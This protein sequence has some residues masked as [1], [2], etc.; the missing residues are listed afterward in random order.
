[1]GRKKQATEEEKK[2]VTKPSALKEF[3]ATHAGDLTALPRFQQLLAN[4]SI[5][6]RLLN[7]LIGTVFE[8]VEATP[9]IEWGKSAVKAILKFFEPK[10]MTRDAFFFPSVDSERKLI[11][12]LRK[13]TSSMVICVFTITNNDLAN[14]IRDARR[15]GVTV[16][17]I[18][19]D[20]CMKMSGSDIQALYDEGF[21]VRTD[22]NRYAHMHNKFVVIDEY[23][24][25]TGSFNWTKQAVKKNQENL[26]VL[27]DPAL[28]KIYIEEF[29]RLWEAFADSERRNLQ[30]VKKEDEQGTTGAVEEK[31]ESKGNT[32]AV[33]EEKEL[34]ID[35]ET[36]EEEK[37]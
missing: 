29:N 20:E 6:K 22:L 12:Y 11:S 31:K 27:D 13:A 24:L 1:M 2:E 4:A 21:A 16:R 8:C 14:A 30:A 34:K 36:V 37:E 5:N 23:L 9:H 3:L 15:R 25:V 33:E 10:G 7:S 17:I 26:T 32:E 19:D 35:S 28:A 18:S